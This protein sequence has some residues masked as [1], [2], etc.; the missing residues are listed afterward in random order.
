MLARRRRSARTRAR[1]NPRSKSEGVGAPGL[2]AACARA[3]I[4]LGPS[5]PRPRRPSYA[6]RMERLQAALDDRQYAAMVE[7]ITRDEV[8]AAAA[9]N[10]VL[11]GTRLALSFGVH[12]LVTMGTFFALGYY[13]MS[14]ATGSPT[15]GAVGGAA[16]M[17]AALLLES[18]LL[19]IRLGRP[20]P[21]EERMPH[22]TDPHLYASP[23]PAAAAAAGGAGAAAAPLDKRAKKQQ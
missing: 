9:R 12:V 3:G 18:T 11:P 2:A 21:L 6:R 10:A 7:D 16:G 15:W 4:S 5:A 13:G 23:P 14:F 20:A 17:T 22:L 19:I 8:A 1:P